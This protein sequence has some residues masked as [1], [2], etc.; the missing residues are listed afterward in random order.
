G[1]SVPAENHEG[2]VITDL[3][4]DGSDVDP[5]AQSSGRGRG[6]G[7]A[8]SGSSISGLHLT[9]ARLNLANPVA[10]K[11]VATLEIAWHNK[12][13]GGA[14]GGHRMT[15]R[16]GDSLH[17]LAAWDPRVAVY[18]DLRGWD[19]EP[20]LGPAEFY[21]NFGRF[22]VNIDVPS[23]WIVAAT[24]VLQNPRQVL[25]STARERLSCVLES[26]ST[27]TIVGADETLASTARRERPVS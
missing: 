1:A 26:D 25:S 3:K 19:T 7:P 11:G 21:N 5:D 24:G 15:L 17:T 27:R 14:G 6:A 22:D 8:S 16:W 2:F 9:S 20:Y 12:L 18:D 10:A 23:G 4:V 13:A